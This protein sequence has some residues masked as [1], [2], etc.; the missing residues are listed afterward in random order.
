[1]LCKRCGLKPVVRHERCG[2]CGNYWKRHGEERPWTLIQRAIDHAEKP[3][4]CKVCG[5]LNIYFDLRCR[6]CY[7]YRERNGHERPYRLWA[8]D[9]ACKNCKRPRAEGMRW[10]KLR[11]HN[12]DQYLRKHKKER[13]KD[14][15]GDG[16]YG[17]CEC[18]YPADNLFEKI[19][20]CNRCFREAKMGAFTVLR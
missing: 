9:M 8:K 10:C 4:W 3:R 17:W 13:P 16:Q 19:P 5:N 15:W 14:F 12:C 20:F 7:R 11:C 6:T 2:A 1:M 18:G